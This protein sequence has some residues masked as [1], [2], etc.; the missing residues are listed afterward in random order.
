MRR[1]TREELAEVRRRVAEMSDQELADML[2]QGSLIS[3]AAQ[4]PPVVV[5]PKRSW[6]ATLASVI[7]V[8][9]AGSDFAARMRGDK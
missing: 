8:G 2:R 6:L 3:R 5:R 9:R 4:S 7:I 1:Y